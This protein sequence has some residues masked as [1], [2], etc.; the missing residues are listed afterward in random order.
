MKW[1]GKVDRRTARR[2]RP[3]PAGRRA[4]RAARAPVRRGQRTRRPRPCSATR[5]SLRSAS[6]SS[7]PPSASW[8][9]SPRPTGGS[10]SWRSPPRARSWRA[11]PGC[12]PDPA[13]PSPASPRASSRSSTSTGELAALQ[14]ACRGRPD[15][16]RIFLEIQVRAAL[17]GNNLEG[18]VRPMMQRVA[19]RLGI[20][21]F[22]FAHIEAVLRIQQRR[23]SPRRTPGAAAR[24]RP[25]TS[26]P[27][28]A[29]SRRLRAGER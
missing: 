11:A 7:A 15:L 16:T 23:L 17:A 4:R 29:C 18:R 21:A 24:G 22:E 28:T 2:A 13:R 26:R 3:G 9:T 19:Q 6:A 20:S 1:I 10:R 27:P 8:A 12:R 25:G 5:I 14:R